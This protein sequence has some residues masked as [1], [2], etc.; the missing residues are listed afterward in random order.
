VK[1]TIELSK[2]EI[3]HIHPDHD[4]YDC[5]GTVQD[6]MEKVQRAVKKKVKP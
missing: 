3:A 5:C 6:I 1:I 2:G 4:F